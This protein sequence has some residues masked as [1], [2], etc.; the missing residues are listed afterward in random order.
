[1]ARVNEVTEN[2]NIDILG[3][4]KS[5]PEF[6]VNG[7]LNALNNN[8][9]APLT[10]LSGPSPA[11]NLNF[12]LWSSA[13]LL[14]LKPSRPCGECSA[15]VK[16]SK[17]SHESFLKIAPEKGSIKV[18]QAHELI[19]FLRLRP[20]SGNQVILIESAHLMTVQAANAL[21]KSFEEPPPS[22]Y[23]FLVS[24]QNRMIL[25]TIRSRSQKIFLAKAPHSSLVEETDLIKASQELLSMISKGEI[26]NALDRLSELDI[27]KAEMLSLLQSWQNTLANVL[28]KQ[29][30]GANVLHSKQN[31][32][33][34]KI[35]HA[36]KIISQAFKECR[37]PVDWSLLLHSLLIKLNRSLAGVQL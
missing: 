37:G 16:L 7:F 15:C 27:E 17:L 13:L 11:V 9:V 14:C 4:K 2:Q 10:L 8:R 30:A 35:S 21:L 24:E 34:Q 32:S 18:E 28:K 20:W 1:L 12:A 26:S 6:Q 29:I 3:L 5:L 23:F 25:P 22:T 31:L 36:L 19:E 33:S